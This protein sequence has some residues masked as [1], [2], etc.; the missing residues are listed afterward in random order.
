MDISESSD[1]MMG[2]SV[3]VGRVRSG[4]GGC[5]FFLGS[6]VVVGGEQYSMMDVSLN[7]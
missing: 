7:H 3:L 2:Q 5:G 1:E 6:W 4:I